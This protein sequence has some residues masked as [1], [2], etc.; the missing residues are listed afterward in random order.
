MSEIYFSV[1]FLSFKLKLPVLI[2][3][4]GSKSVL[5]VVLCWK[6]Q[7]KKLQQNGLKRLTNN[8]LFEHT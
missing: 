5:N 6:W 8:Q 1:N 3:V 4:E 7:I 2:I